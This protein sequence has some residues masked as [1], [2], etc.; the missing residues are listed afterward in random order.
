MRALLGRSASTRPPRSPAWWLH[1][2]RQGQGAGADAG[3][4]RRGCVRTGH[5]GPPPRSRTRRVL[6]LV[7]MNLKNC[8][9]LACQG[10]LRL[11][12]DGDW[13]TIIRGRLSGRLSAGR[14][15]GRARLAQDGHQ[16]VHGLCRQEVDEEGG[17]PV[18]HQALGDHAVV[19]DRVE[20]AVALD[21]QLARKAPRGGCEALYRVRV[22]VGPQ[23]RSTRPAALSGRA[24]RG[25]GGARWR[26]GAP[27]AILLRPSSS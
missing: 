24:G 4:S 5:A 22:G 1:A 9:C 15:G 20:H 21:A 27:M 17:G 16:V 18:Q 10:K 25:A 7:L 3:Q 8:A 2:Q 11:V 19:H 23:R 14:A 13:S 26:P 6:S 12:S